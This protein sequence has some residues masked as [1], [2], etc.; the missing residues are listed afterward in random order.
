ME[1][2]NLIELIKISFDKS[3]EINNNSNTNNILYYDRYSRKIFDVD[4]SVIRVYDKKAKNLKDKFFIN[5]PKESLIDIAV[6]KELKYLLCLL[7]VNNNKNNKN[8][9]KKNLI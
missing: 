4:E 6:D 2:K 5:I 9:W 1:A 8:Q 7:I 3:K